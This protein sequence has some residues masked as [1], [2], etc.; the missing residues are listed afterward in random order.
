M[1]EKVS[2]TAVIKIFG[3]GEIGKSIGKCLENKGF[4][5]AYKD[6]K[7][8]N[9]SEF[10][11]ILHVCIPYSDS[12]VREVYLEAVNSRAKI[13]IIHSTVAPTTTREI[14]YNLNFF[15]GKVTHRI[16]VVHSPVIGVHPNLF[17]GL[18]TFKKWIGYDYPSPD[19]IAHLCELGMQVY[20]VEGSTVTEFLKLLCTTYYGKC[21]AF[22]WDA[23]KLLKENGIDFSLFTEWNENYNQGYE[24]MGMKNVV[25]P[26]LKAEDEK[27]G[28]HCVVPNAEIL[29]KIGLFVD[30]ILKFS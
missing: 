18:M 30:D 22:T 28:G 24:K 6:L 16:E 27:I 3:Y 7:G 2:E 17:E 4:P 20:P 26:I 19:A 5:F 10:C 15:D 21:I 13:V 29:K 8:S 12:F 14:Y 1:R 9:G 23:K 25:R 11:D